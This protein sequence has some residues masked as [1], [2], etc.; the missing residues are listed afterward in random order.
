MGWLF[1]RSRS[2]LAFTALV[3]IATLCIT[4]AARAS[5]STSLAENIVS[6]GASTASAGSDASS[7]PCDLRYTAAKCQSS[8]PTV[9]LSTYAHGDT[10]NCTFT[11]DITWGDGHSST[12]TLIDPAD[13]WRV[14]AQHT[15]SAT[16]VYTVTAT[17]EASSGCTLDPFVVT[18]TLT[19]PTPS[20]CQSSPQPRI[21]WSQTAGPQGTR[22]Y[23]T[24]NGWYANDVVTIHLPPKGVFHVSRTSWRANS[25]GDWKI[26]ITVGKLAPPRTYEIAFTQTTCKGIKISGHFKITMTRA[27]FG[28]LV[29][30]TYTL[31]SAAD[32][33]AKVTDGKDW[34]N[35]I[36]HKAVNLISKAQT[37]ISI[38]ISGLDISPVHN[39]LNALIKALKKSHNNKKDPAVQQDLK[40]LET[41]T[42]KLRDALIGIVPELEFIF[43]PSAS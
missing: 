4:P 20:A 11:W 13:G 38:G 31:V 42:N 3:M 19:K 28:D 25:S 41:D 29:S 39:D 5:A 16:G 8:D 21:Y 22:F 2:A 35:S 12:A 15:Y 43:P 27:Q 36:V 10:S 7:K 6:T 18:F 32:E 33:V 26:N 14:T 34:D 37:I 9:T 30:A 23:F 40:R 24:G 1:T 17:G